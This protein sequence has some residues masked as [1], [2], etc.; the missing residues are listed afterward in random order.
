MITVSP[1]TYTANCVN[2]TGYLGQAPYGDF[3]AGQTVNITL[4]GGTDIPHYA[5]DLIFDV[6]LV[7]T[8]TSN[9]S[10]KWNNNKMSATL[11]DV[12]STTTKIFSLAGPNPSTNYQVY[13]GNSGNKEVIY[14]YQNSYNHNNSMTDI[15]FSITTDNPN[16][17]AIWV[18]KEFIMDIRTCNAACL[19]C[20]ATG[21]VNV[22][23]SCDPGLGYM[24]NNYSCYNSCK[25]GYGY[26][27]D[28][29]MCVWCDLHCTSCYATFDNCSTCVTSSTWKSSLFYNDTY[30]YW[31]C[32][33]TCPS[34]SPGYYLNTTIN[35]CELCDPVCTSCKTNSSYCYSCIADYGWTGYYC[36]QPCPTA[37]Y[38]TNN[39]T[40]CTQCNLTCIDC[41]D[42]ITCSS[43]T[44]N[45][46]HMAYLLGVTCYTTCPAGYYGDT[47]YNLGPN[48]CKACAAG[49]ATCTANPTPCQSCQNGSYLYNSTCGSTCPNGTIAYSATNQCLDCS[50]YCVD[51]TINMHFSDSLNSILYI[52]MTF[53]N[54]LSPTFDMTTFQT[55][56]I[57][58][59]DSAAYT[60]T[61]QP[62]TSSSY[63]IL[64]EPIGYI[65]LYNYTVTVTTKDQPA[66]L[67]LANDSLP[68]KPSVYSKTATTNWFLLKSPSMS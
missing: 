47:N 38:F 23:F 33:A 48:T 43:C 54:V 10:R 9:N 50:I 22:C 62:L 3:T 60:V 37:Y 58:S 13:C 5:V 44:L 36:Y 56:S 29:A 68:F 59:V 28:P 46:T 6:I 11:I 52:D 42:L 39:N 18:A 12:N 20:N 64:V 2:L 32:I 63:R 7:D 35:T 27:D 55:V 30:G 61:Y 67:E 41:T 16:T 40:N 4:S 31:T 26:T 51:L 53:T 66:T 45:G 8:D 19:S 15:I 24:L 17:A 14:Q 65:F 1:N 57:E 21:T 25:P 49:C 34:G